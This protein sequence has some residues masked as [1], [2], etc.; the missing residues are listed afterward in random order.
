MVMV[1]LKSGVSEYPAHYP[2]QPVLHRITSRPAIAGNSRC[3]VFKLGPKYNCEN[4]ASNI[5]LSYGAD[6]DK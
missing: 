6:V 1:L 5:A 3:S 4:H 2:I